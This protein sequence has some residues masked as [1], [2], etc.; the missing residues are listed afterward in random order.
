[1][2]G[3]AI[4]DVGVASLDRFIFGT[5]GFGG[6]CVSKVTVVAYELV[7][8]ELLSPCAIR[9]YGSILGSSV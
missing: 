9:G 5:C 6:G 4:L 7:A 8:Y 1:M 3:V 2:A